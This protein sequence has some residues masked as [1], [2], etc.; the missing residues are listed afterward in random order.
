M[1]QD[2]KHKYALNSRQTSKRYTMSK[3]K[4]IKKC[5]EKIKFFA[6]VSEK[7]LKIVGKLK[8]KCKSYVSDHINQAANAVPLPG[9]IPLLPAT[10]TFGCWVSPL[11]RFASP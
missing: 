10:E 7:G 4:Y 2:K 5:L 6:K 11:A 8:K 3:K 9:A 1:T